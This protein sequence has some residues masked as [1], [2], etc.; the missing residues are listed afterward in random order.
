MP[1]YD[2]ECPKCREQKRDQLERIAAPDPPCPICAT[3]MT[4]VFISKAHAIVP[5]DIPGGLKVEHGICGPNGEPTYVYSKS[6]LRTRLAEKGWM[7]DEDHVTAPGTD[8]NAH[9]TRWATPSKETLQFDEPEMKEA[10]RRAMAEWLGVSMEEYE[11]IVAPSAKSGIEVPIDRVSEV[12]LREIKQYE[13]VHR[14]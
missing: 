8:K 12:I 11:R 5:D 13:L 3:P 7:I 6:E 4:R 2:R 10:R 9:T 14:T 1:M